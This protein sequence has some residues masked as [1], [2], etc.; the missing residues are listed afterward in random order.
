VNP[1]ITS[2][3]SWHLV[4]TTLTRDET[5]KSTEPVTIRRWRIAVPTTATRNESS[6][7]SGKLTERFTF[8]ADR[9]DLSVT[10]WADWPLKTSLLATGDTALGRGARGAIPLHLVYESRDLL[11]EPNRPRTWHLVMELAPSAKPLD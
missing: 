7:F 3:V 2:E 4:G 1:H 6:L 8:G 5:L 11:L 9:T 10:S